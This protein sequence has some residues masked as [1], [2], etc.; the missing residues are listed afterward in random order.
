VVRQSQNYFA[1]A[2]SAAVLNAAAIAA[3][4]LFTVLSSVH[5]FP[6]PDLIGA[7]SPLSGSPS[8]PATD[9]GPSTTTAVRRAADDPRS[10]T[11]APS[12][13]DR[14][15][16]PGEARSD[17]AGT[18]SGG[19]SHSGAS[20]PVPGGGSPGGGLGGGGGSGSIG[21]GPSAGPIG[22]TPGGDLPDPV[23]S[24]VDGIGGTVSGVSATVG[25]A[26]NNTVSGVDAS[27]GGQ[28]SS[29]GVTQ[30]VQSTTNSLLG[31]SSGNTPRLNG[32]GSSGGA[33]LPLGG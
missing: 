27:T 8:T 31:S 26:V 24:T 5:G 9:R 3:F 11:L 12:R 33:A 30:A 29:A 22:G 6:L 19:G 4:V 21:G 17:I 7:A 23:G 16:P 20:A 28:L 25:S 15:K 32:T 13:G 14:T 2:V 1:A 18:G 10:P